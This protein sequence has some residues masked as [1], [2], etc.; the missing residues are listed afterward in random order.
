[1]DTVRKVRIR[2]DSIIDGEELNR[3]YEGEYRRKSHSH[4]LVYT[5][6]VGNV[7]TKVGIEAT[8]DQ[9][10]IH[11]VGGITS[12]MLFDR[13][14]ETVMKYEALSLR[15]GFLLHTYEYRLEEAEDG[16]H[17][18]V[19]YGLNDGSG[20]PEIQGSQKLTIEFLENGEQLL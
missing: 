9:M 8:E 3:E 20:Q 2:L 10:L 5:D 18:S 11:R 14:T 1:M 16:V 7:P 13:M 15:H 19:R 4:D 12:D 17:I 6:H